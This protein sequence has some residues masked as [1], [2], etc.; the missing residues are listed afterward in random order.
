MQMDCPFCQ[1]PSDRL[2]YEGDRVVGLWDRFPVSPGHA[3]LIPRRH[4]PSWFEAT[5]AEQLELIQALEIARQ[6]IGHRHRPDGYNIGINDGKA[7]GQT[8]FHLHVHLI[9]RYAG[10]VDVPAGGVRHVIPELAN[11]LERPADWSLPHEA[12]LVRGEDDRSC[13]IFWG[14]STWP[15]RWTLL[16]RSR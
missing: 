4:V 10:D 1:I 7:A 13:P 9:P 6:E 3:L 2:F 16:S 11:Y 8:V 15:V 12:S 5:P 14:T